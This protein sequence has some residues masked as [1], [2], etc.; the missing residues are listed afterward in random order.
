LRVAAQMTS[1]RTSATM[2]TVTMMPVVELE[3]LE[4]PEE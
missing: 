2:I 4:L 1:P 3:L